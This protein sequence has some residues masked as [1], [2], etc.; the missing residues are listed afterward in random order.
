MRQRHLALAGWLLADL[1]LVLALVGLGDSDVDSS[2]ATGVTDTVPTPVPACTPGLE[3]RAQR[4]QV[5]LAGLPEAEAGQLDPPPEFA[6]SVQLQ[7]RQ[8]LDSNQLAGRPVGMIQTFTSLPQD[9]REAPTSLWINAAL[10][11]AFD[12]A[13][14]L[15]PV[16]PGTDP[17]ADMRVRHFI[18][19]GPDGTAAIEWFLLKECE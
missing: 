15:G 5:N 14:E 12:E 13:S 2:L 19:D 8:Q 11:E 4:F 10:L 1:S 3:P 7:V 16:L 6:E 18:G 17:Q 9:D